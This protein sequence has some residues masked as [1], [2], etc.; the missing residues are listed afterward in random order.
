MANEPVG[1]PHG[2]ND[3]VGGFHFPQ[4]IRIQR[5]AVY[6]T[7][8][9]KGLFRDR[10]GPVV[11]DRNLPFPAPAVSLSADVRYGRHGHSNPT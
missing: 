1:F 4:S 10:Q 7:E 2:P 11:V 3:A 8:A 9:Q 5:L 6:K